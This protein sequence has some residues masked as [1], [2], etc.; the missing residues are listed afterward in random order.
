[1]AWSVGAGVSDYETDHRLY[2]VMRRAGWSE[3]VATGGFVKRIDRERLWV[4][5]LQAMDALRLADESER[6]AMVEALSE[7]VARIIVRGE[8]AT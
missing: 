6:V 3:D 4:S 2:A 7:S 8:S 5:W 1:M